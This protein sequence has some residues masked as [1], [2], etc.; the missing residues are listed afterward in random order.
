MV[1][2]WPCSRSCLAQ[3]GL[4]YHLVS[5]QV[6]PKVDDIEEDT[7]EEP[8]MVQADGVKEAALAAQVSLCTGDCSSSVPCCSP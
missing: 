1:S 8:T 6:V 2:A 3:N 7:F 5:S 4:Y